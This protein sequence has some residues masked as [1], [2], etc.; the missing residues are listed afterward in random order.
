VAK[1]FAS[2]NW[3]IVNSRSKILLSKVRQ[4]PRCNTEVTGRPNKLYCSAN[5][6]KRYAEFKHNSMRDM[7][8]AVECPSEVID[9]ISDWLTQG[10][11][12]GYGKRYSVIVFVI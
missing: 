4:F 5:C 10:V 6:R 2:D 3:V 9:Q 8:W 1:I 11:G 7:L 12:S